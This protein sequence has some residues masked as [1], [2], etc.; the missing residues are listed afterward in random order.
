MAPESGERNFRATAPYL[1]VRDL[2]ASLEYYHKSLELRETDKE[3]IID[4]IKMVETS[5]P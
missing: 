5:E 2:K 1:F 3:T 4:K